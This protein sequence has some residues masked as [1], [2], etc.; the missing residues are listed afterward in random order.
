[1]LENNLYSS[2]QSAYRERH[3]TKTAL[4]KEQSDILSAL[5][6]GSETGLLMLDLSAAFDTIDKG[7]L[8]HRLNSLYGI[9]GDALV[10]FFL[11]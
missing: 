9:S 11:L 5:D 2:I 10:T 1:M 7:I 8:L 6:S 3:S 4:L